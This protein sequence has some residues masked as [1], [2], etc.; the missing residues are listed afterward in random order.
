MN[1]RQFLRSSGA[2]V[3][4]SAF[5]SL[6]MDFADQRKRVGLIGCGWSGQ[7][8]LFRSK[9]STLCSWPRPIIGTRYR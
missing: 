6:A 5:P 1:R 2:L 7:T 4:A 9:T 8:D 3:A